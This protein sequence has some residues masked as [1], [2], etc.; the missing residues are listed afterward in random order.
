KKTLLR[1]FKAHKYLLQSD[2]IDAQEKALF[3][4]Y[5]QETSSKTNLQYS[6]YFLSELLHRHFKRPV[7]ILID[8]YDTP[9]NHAYLKFKDESPQ[10]FEQVVELFR[11]LMGKALKSNEYLK[12]ALVTGILR[13]AKANIFSDWNNVREYTLLDKS[14]ANSYGFTQEEVD[15]LLAQVPVRTSKAQIQHWYNGYNFGGVTIYNPWSIMCCLS[16]EGVLDHYW[17]DSGG[18]SLVDA[19]L[20]KDEVQEDLHLLIR[21]ESIDRIINTKIAFKELYHPDSFYT[22]LLFSGYLNPEPIDRLTDLYRLSIPNHELAY[23]YEKRVLSWV[24]GK[25]HITSREYIS[26]AKLLVEGE[27][28]TFQRTLQEFLDQAASFQHT[29]GAAEVFYNGFMLAF[30]SMLSSYYR[31][32][33]EYES[34]VGK[35]DVVLIPKSK[36]NQSGL[37][38]EYKVCQDPDQLPATAQAGLKQILIKDYAA[39]VRSHDHVQKILAVSLAFCGKKVTV[40]SD[41]ISV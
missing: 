13:I 9:I 8:E 40:E 27:V 7:Y 17:I 31:I 24:E 36:S 30:L 35:A 21:G 11:D 5:L 34:G 3:S 26:L 2:T 41:V 20:L 23:I 12:K 29:G 22:L 15:T 38:L 28:A 25:L 1:L 39:K 16:N 10:T 37:V 6:L 19:V 32:E 4:E 14:F 18:T 33:S